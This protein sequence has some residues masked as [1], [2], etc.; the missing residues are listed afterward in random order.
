MKGLAI[1]K[2]S[3]PCWFSIITLLLFKGTTLVNSSS[4]QNK[5]GVPEQVRVWSTLRYVL[6]HETDNH[7][8]NDLYPFITQL[9][10]LDLIDNAFSIGLEIDELSISDAV[11]QLL[12]KKYKKKFLA[13]LFTLYYDLYPTGI[14]SGTD[15]NYELD[16]S[17]YFIL[18]N[19]RHNEPDDVFYLK[20]KELERQASIPDAQ[21]ITSPDDIVIGANTKAPLI[22]LYGCPNEQFEEFNRN[23]FSEAIQE[24]AKFRFIWRSTCIID[25]PTDI[26]TSFPLSLSLKSNTDL[27]VLLQNPSFD[28]SI[29]NGFSK[30]DGTSVT[31]S[32]EHLDKLDL[33]VTSLIANHYYNTRNFTDTLLFAKSIVNNFPLY[34]PQLIKMKLNEKEEEKIIN[35]DKVLK[36]KGIDYNLIGLFINGQHLK[37]STLNEYTLLNAINNE[38]NEFRNMVSALKTLNKKFGMKAAKSILDEFSSISLSHLKTTQPVKIDL[39]RIPGFSDTVI[40]FNDIE[41]DEQYSE[42]SD[43]VSVFFDKSKFGEVPEYKQNWNEI[44]FVIDFNKLDDPNMLESLTGL[45]RV[46]TV[47]SQG[48]P[49]RIGLLPLNSNNITYTDDDSEEDPA[50]KIINKIYDLKKYDIS[51]LVRFL[52]MLHDK[53]KNMKFKEPTLNSILDVPNYKK[54]TEDLQIYETSIIVDGEIYPFRKNTW[55]YLISNVI[56]KD[57]EY[58]RQELN[59][60]ATRQKTKSTG[61]VDVRGIL[62]LASANSRNLKYM[63]EYYS[64]SVYTTVNLEALEK[65]N[66]N[67][68]TIYEVGN[69]YNLLHTVTLAGDFGTYISLKRIHNL[70][71]VKYNGIRIRVVHTGD[72]ESSTWKSLK[73]SIDAGNLK[74]KLP[75]LLT[76]TK[77][78]KVTHDKLKP[79]R[80]IGVDVLKA[81]L[82]H[83][84]DTYLQDSTFIVI[85]GRFIHLEPKEVPKTKEFASLIQKEA[86]RTLNAAAATEKIYPSLSDTKIDSDLIEILSSIL[87]KM[88]YH[89]DQIYQDGIEYTTET[90]LPRMGVSAM[91]KENDFTIF[92]SKHGN[93]NIIDMLLIIDPLEERTQKL[94]SLITKFI[95]FGSINVKIVLLPTE[96]LT[97]VPIERIYVDNYSEAIL[98]EN[99][100]RSN[101]EVDVESPKSMSLIDLNT[102]ESIILEVYA[103]DDRFYLSEGNVDGIDD[104]HLELIDANGNVVDELHTM[105]TFGYGQFHIKNMGK[106]FTVRVHEDNPDF[107][108]SKV[109]LYGF[110]DFI[111]MDG[112]DIVDFN[113]HKLYVKVKQIESTK[114]LNSEAPD[115]N[116]NIFTVLEDSDEEENYKE[117]ILAVISNVRKYSNKER[118]VFWLLDAPYLSHSFREFIT[119]FNENTVELG[120][121]IKLMRYD[122]PNWLRPQ[123]FRHRMISVSKLLYLDVLFPSNI[124]RVVYMA[125]TISS[126]DPVELLEENRAKKATFSLFKMKEKGYWNEGYWKKMLH[127]NGLTFHSIQPGFIINMER[128]RE[129]NA[130]DKLRIHYQRLSSD[131]NSLVNIDQDLLNNLQIEIPLGTLK[132]NF[133]NELTPDK[134]EV[135]QWMNKLNNATKKKET[136]SPSTDDYDY[137]NDEE[138]YLNIHD[139]L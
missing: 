84:P 73:A 80:E 58:I 23:L 17:N 59:A 39:H 94:L 126:F 103:V 7:I 25:Y 134:E 77:T 13:N 75:D 136:W 72:L 137:D 19:Q 90:V 38:Y 62:H 63:P 113:P 37:L 27:S 32:K 6:S 71:R 45:N 99:N 47:V 104:I 15:S 10:A 123:R 87:T 16:N 78:V 121:T 8:L 107:E 12:E 4:L 79:P 52:E 40:Y 64:D 20:S 124:D 92:E 51:E 74:E 57:T 35:Y 118:F 1:L 91:L 122:W 101:F 119:V 46:L 56:R 42:L 65:I 116:I 93:H 50:T 60:Q 70:L 34:A 109:S 26:G 131:I 97:I 11:T 81:W 43:D 120:A 114:I 22:V 117:M 125:P 44:I 100:I 85:N 49:Q 96:K 41:N 67:R 82:P 135:S 115:E 48:Y 138:E 76:T 139:E 18:N 102:V 89:G 28:V 127:D 61:Y 112:F 55:N 86:I 108:V 14:T 9:D 54:Q 133:I 106:N 31:L 83:V 30:P 66:K 69:D 111:A 24:N 29:P 88:Y 95:D 21:I 130:G 5:F 132:S 36:K 68:V 53:G 128:L 2:V 98:T 3:I 129:L 110:S 33:K 105:T